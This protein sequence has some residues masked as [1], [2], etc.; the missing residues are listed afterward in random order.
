M[1]TIPLEIELENETAERSS[2]NI[3]KLKQIHGDIIACIYSIDSK[4]NSI[5]QFFFYDGK[6]H[7]TNGYCMDIHLIDTE[8]RIKMLFFSII[9]NGIPGFISSKEYIVQANNIIS[10]S[11]YDVS[12]NNYFVFKYNT[13]F[14]PQEHIYL[15]CN[16]SKILNE[17]LS[18]LMKEKNNQIH[19]IILNDD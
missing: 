6:V 12:K 9:L 4:G 10:F 5:A 18:I 17:F 7:D 8:N 3:M 11:N 2:N 19:E 1:N 15:D 14:L 13:I 16:G